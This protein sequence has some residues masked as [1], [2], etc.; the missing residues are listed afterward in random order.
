M[1][2]TADRVDPGLEPIMADP[3]ARRRFFGSFSLGHLLM[4]LT[5]LLAFLLVLAVLRDTSVTSFVA[6]AA[7][8]LPAG[9]TINAADVDLIEISGDALVGTVLTSDQVNEVIT[10]G[11]V[12]TRALSVG[13]LLQS[14]DF[15]AAGQRSQIRSMSIPISPTRAVAGS[16]KQGDLV[17]VL[18]SGDGV[19]WH[20]MTSAEVLAVADATKGGFA[21]SDY[22]VTIAVDPTLSLRLACAMTNFSLDIVRSTGATPLGLLSPP[23]ECG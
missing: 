5:S 7:A 15:T 2:Q 4:V 21:S 1:T 9:T 16:L 13:T 22:T 23:E 19:S 11:Q 8:D 14:T 17:D 10:G 6:Q 3:V 18:A 20:V 12:T